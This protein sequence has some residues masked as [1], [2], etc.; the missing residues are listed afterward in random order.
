MVYRLTIFVSFGQETT[1]NKTQQV[2]MLKMLFHKFDIVYVLVTAP[3]ALVQAWQRLTKIP[4][5]TQQ[6]N[7]PDDQNNFQLIFIQKIGSLIKNYSLRLFVD[8]SNENIEAEKQRNL[9]VDYDTATLMDYSSLASAIHR[10]T[11]FVSRIN[12][13]NLPVS[14]IVFDLDETLIDTNGQLLTTTTKKQLKRMRA[15]F[16]YVVLW[17]HGC[18]RHVD[19]ILLTVMGDFRKIFDLT[20]SRC[21]G[22]PVSNKGMGLVFRRL[23]EMYGISEISF[24]VLVDDQ[25]Q[26]YVGDYDCFLFVDEA[27]SYD[28]MF[29][30]LIQIINE[31][32]SL[33]A[34]L[35]K[36]QQVIRSLCEDVASCG[37]FSY[38]SA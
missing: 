14:V 12:K 37:T 11:I 31:R 35:R 21:I 2:K 19:N 26:N 29:T 34:R 30:S 5:R 24:C 23:N 20:I 13:P 16:D 3:S 18:N 4:Y 38:L 32:F 10:K 25:A 28:H 7:S 6:M 36:Q 1:N 33:T 22:D 15:I 8:E 9:H 17:S 27:I